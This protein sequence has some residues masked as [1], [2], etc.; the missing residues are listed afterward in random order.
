MSK[1]C[2]LGV[3]FTDKDGIDYFLWTD[4]RDM[5]TYTSSII[6][7]NGQ[8]NTSPFKRMSVNNILGTKYFKIDIIGLRLFNVNG[9]S[10][11]LTEIHDI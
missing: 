6:L 10:N 8:V 4:T 1:I 3:Y 7:F 5:T 2:T 9:L 11:N